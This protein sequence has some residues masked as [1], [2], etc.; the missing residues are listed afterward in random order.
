ME[1][2]HPFSALQSWEAVDT[3]I[4]FDTASKRFSLP[5]TKTNNTLYTKG[6]YLLT[7]TSI[8]LTILLAP[9]GGI[10]ADEMGLGKTI[11]ALALILL[12]PSTTEMRN[13]DTDLYHL[14]CKATIIFCPNHLCKVHYTL[15]L[16]FSY[17][18]T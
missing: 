15:Y 4:L 18:L 7:P 10:L 3:D 8:I 2:G 11:V 14:P 13:K 5:S 9:L 12:N 1:K 6:K 16:V 17:V